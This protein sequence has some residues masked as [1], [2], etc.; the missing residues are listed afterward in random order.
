MRTKIFISSTYLD[1]IPFREK[2]WEVLSDQDLHILGMEK[3]G[4]RSSAPLLTCLKE[5]TQSDI[6][7][8][9]I[10]YRYGSIDKKTSK[11][12]TEL[13]YE[14]ALNC[15]KEILIY[16]FDENGFIQPRFIDFGTEG[17][18]LLKFK[19]LLRDNHTVDTFDSPEDLAIK[20]NNRLHEVIPKLPHKYVRPKILQAKLHRFMIKDKNWIAF[21]GYLDDTPLEIFTGPADEEMFP[22]PNSIKNGTISE[23]FSKY[24]GKSSICFKYT[25]IYGYINTIGGLEHVFNKQMSQY[26]NIITKLLTD[27]TPLH[28]ILKVIDEMHLDNIEETE[29]WKRGVKEA[30]TN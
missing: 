12:F 24:T 14:R 3:F 21:I 4:A 6:Y 25:D 30:L 9:I 16:H 29:D 1:L 26:D 5:V 19:E 11:S 22:I 7:V 17:N 23:K 18:K 15:N 28:T 8:G 10:A 2:L 13:E 27:N 20:V